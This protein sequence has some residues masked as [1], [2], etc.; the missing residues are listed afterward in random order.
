M[1]ICTQGWIWTQDAAADG[2]LPAEAMRKSDSVEVELTQCRMQAVR[3]GV[4]LYTR[5]LSPGDPLPIN[6]DRIKINDDAPLD[7]EIRTVASER[8][9]V[10]QQEPP[11]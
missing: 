9:M 1:M 10:V 6:I 5:R 4:D 2:V 11:G 8:R 3:E 7:K